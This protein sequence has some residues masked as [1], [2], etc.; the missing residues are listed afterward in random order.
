MIGF[1]KMDT[2]VPKLSVSLRPVFYMNESRLAQ[3]RLG[4]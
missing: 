2:K 1:K 3:G 4:N